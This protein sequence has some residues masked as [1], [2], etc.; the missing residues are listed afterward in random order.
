MAAVSPDQ[1]QLSLRHNVQGTVYLLQFEPA[2]KHAQHCVGWT[3]GEVCERLAVHLQGRGSPLI[4]AAVAAGVDVHLAATYGGDAVLAAALEEPAQHR[5]VLRDLPRPPPR[6]NCR[7]GIVMTQHT[8]PVATT[9]DHRAV[10]RPTDRFP[11]PVA[12][13]SQGS[14]LVL[15]IGP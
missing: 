7:A 13:G 8:L 11:A 5:P 9:D 15:A 1:Q 4:R 14:T 2:Y 6:R 10:S 3:E 12:D